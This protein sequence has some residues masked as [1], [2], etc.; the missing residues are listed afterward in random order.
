MADRK[1][2]LTL[3]ARDDAS[4][5]IRKVGAALGGVEENAESAAKQIA[6]GL[7]AAADL[8]EEELSGAKR[9]ADAL[10]SALGPELSGRT[11]VDGLVDEFRRLGASIEDIEANADELA[12]SIGKL[13]SVGGGGLRQVRSQVDGVD[14]GMRRVGATTD[15]TRSVMA[16]FTGNAISQ[17]PGVTG[18]LGPLNQAIGQFGEYAA[19]GNIRLRQFAAA[20]GPLAGGVAI[21][22][23]VSQYFGEI[24]ERK[25]FNAEQ[26][27]EW[28]QA[29]LD[30]EE[31][32]GLIADR[33]ADGIFETGTLDNALPIF[34]EYGID[35]AKLAK[36]MKFTDEQLMEFVTTVAGLPTPMSEARILYKVLADEVNNYRASSDGAALATQF[37]GDKA[38]DAAPALDRFGG[39]LEDSAD[40]AASAAK[41]GID[42]AEAA[43]ELDLANR[44][45]ATAAGWLAD[46]EYEAERA[47][48]EYN[49]AWD[50]LTGEID[51]EQAL[52]NL[53]DAFAAVADAAV[54]EGQSVEDAMREQ[55]REILDA[56]SK[57]I[58]Y[59][60]EILGLPP[61]ALTD[62][63]ALIDEGKVAEAEAA[64][65][66]LARDRRV[67]LIVDADKGLMDPT[68]GGG[69]GGG[70]IAPLTADERKWIAAGGGLPERFVEGKERGG[71]VGAGKMYEVAERGA[72]E[73]LN[74]GGRTFLLMGAQGGTVTPASS[75]AGSGVAQNGGGNLIVQVAVTAPPD[76]ANP[77]AW[78][79]A[80][81]RGL[82]DHVRVNGPLPAGLF[83]AG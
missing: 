39:S 51:A 9:A 24:A 13:D 14:D 6:K 75:G 83:R 73:L 19:E 40:G 7:S 28:T 47:L 61:A 60:R 18:A 37:V 72:P 77:Y 46:K 69:G 70:G 33:V 56:K 29:L 71:P 27:K 55:R 65:T 82:I 81:A 20:L 67:R 16:N 30:G 49:A 17:L 54:R 64:L 31:V 58:D 26:V 25:A 11:D 41:A 8:L 2:G 5:V 23:G 68:E 45:A 3:T 59:G 38:E 10:S 32:L 4:S 63:L 21:L 48:R 36:I 43:V 44:R 76:T 78:G 1:I 80:V 53:Q 34:K 62:I 15:N 52:M 57:V 42:A 50:E 22:K 66:V 74:V 79:Q 12:A 35:A